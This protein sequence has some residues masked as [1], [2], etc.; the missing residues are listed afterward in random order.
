MPGAGRPLFQA[1]TANLDPQTDARV[2]VENPERGPLLII[3]GDDDHTVPWAIANASFKRQTRNPGVTEIQKIEGR[4]HSLVFDGG[5][6]EVADVALDFVRR[7]GP[8][9]RRAPREDETFQPEPR[10]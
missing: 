10:A 8:A 1:A 9:S 2:D 3:S 5:W 4:G 7:H 6:R